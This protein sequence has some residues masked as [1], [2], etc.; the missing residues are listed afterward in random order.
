MFH[1]FTKIANNE[2]YIIAEMSANH[3]GSLDN[4]LQI[5]RNAAQSGAD[6]LKIQTYTADTIT[7][8]C[9]NEFFRIHGGLWDGYK[10]Y[11]LYKEAGTPYEWHKPI[12]E[13]C[14][15][16]GI[17]FLSTPF[18]PSAV[19]FLEE[20]GSEAYKIASFELNDLPL[21][22]YAASKGK[23]MIMS[24]GMASLDDIQD[25]INACQ[26]V[27]NNQI[28]LLKCCSEYPANWEDMH[29]GNIP[30]MKKRF[31]VPVGLSDH[32]MG[33]LGAIVATALG[34]QVIE[35][36]VKIEGIDSAD[37]AFSMNMADFGRMVKDIKSAKVMA[38]GPNYGLT[39]KEKASTCF[40]RSLFAVQDINKGDIITSS[41]VKSIRPNNGISPKYLENMIGK[42]AGKDIKYGQPITQDFFDTLL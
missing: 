16:V 14:K 27:G 8:N 5:V 18:D 40:R 33:S 12:M 29:L 31:S 42:S 39:S 21:I 17:D 10:L 30:D 41:N 7:I 19:D 37:S 28:V 35:K 13:E 22:K 25:A 32:S 23:P 34:A 3:G 6:C 38:K 2:V 11:D 15:K 4:A 24:C 9:D 36:H 26:S 1:L 20:L